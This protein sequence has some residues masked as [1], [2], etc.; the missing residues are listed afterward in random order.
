MKYEIDFSSAIE[1]TI[2][3]LFKENKIN[4]NS[5]LII[6]ILDYKVD[7]FIDALNKINNKIILIAYDNIE[8]SNLSNN[9]ELITISRFLEKEELSYMANEI[10]EE[11]DNSY[12]LDLSD[13]I[14]YES[15]YSKILGK[16][17][18]LEKEDIKKIYIPYIYGGMYKGLSKFIK[19]FSDAKIGLINVYNA[20][21]FDGLDYDEIVAKDSIYN[22]YIIIE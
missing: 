22:Y 14:I 7:E 1:Y 11:Y 4:E 9:Y 17:I 12:L 2:N 21:N 13:N 20:N 10:K 16:K 6:P 5:I 18:L 3:N 8:I 19:L 15:Y